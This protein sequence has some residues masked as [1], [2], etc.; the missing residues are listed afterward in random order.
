MMNIIYIVFGIVMVLWGAGKLTDGATS[1]AARMNIPPMVIGLTVVAMGTSMPE[2]FISFISALRGTTD[3]AVGNVVGSNIFNTMLIVGT[4]AMVAPMTIL[5]STVRKDIPFTALAS[6]MLIPMT[7]IGG[8]ISRIDA[9]IL[10]AVFIAFMVYT[11]YTAMKG[12]SDDTPAEAKQ[13]PV[14]KGIAFFLI[15]LTALVV[16]SNV[17]VDGATAVASL[18]GVSEAVI[19][20]TIVAGGTSLPELATSVVA[21]RKGQSAIAMGNVIGSNVFNILMILGVTGL[22]HPMAIQGITWLDLT[23]MLGSVVLLW[24]FSYTRY[25]V[26]RWEGAVLVTIF[27]AYMSWL[28]IQATTAPL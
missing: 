21:A 24:L 8:D 11:V 4:A 16:G 15:G 22:I 26:A 23:V 20:L 6:A 14:W 3:L 13:M 1:L 7:I 19:G 2:F 9:A 10:F 25:T 27:L 28:V 12:K 17:F 18:L 5:K